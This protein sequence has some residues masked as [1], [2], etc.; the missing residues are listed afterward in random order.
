MKRALTLM[1][2]LFMTLTVLGQ[3]A[4]VEKSSF[5]YPKTAAGG[6]AKAFIVANNVG[7]EA[8]F[9]AFNEKRSQRSREQVPFDELLPQLLALR[10]QLGELV[11]HSVVEDTPEHVALLVHY[12]GGGAWGKLEIRCEKQRPHRI[13]SFTIVP[14]AP[15]EVFNKS[16]DMAMGLQSL[17][18]KA[19]SDGE[20]PAIAV[21][22]ANKESIV[23]AA[24]TGMRTAGGK[25][26]VK[27]TDR[28]HIGSI[29]KAM[30][31]TVAARLVEAG[32][33]SWK[34]SIADHFPELG[35][36]NPYST[37]ELRQVLRHS[38][39]IPPHTNFDMAGMKAMHG[40][41]GSPSQKREAW[42]RGVLQ[43]APVA[44]V[45]ASANYSNA[46]YSLV[47]VM[48]E[49]AS[50]KAFEGLMKAT[51]F[52]PLQLTSA[53][54]GWPREE[55]ESAPNGHYGRIVHRDTREYFLGPCLAPAGDVHLSVGDL[56]QFGRMHLRGLLGEDGLLQAKTI[57]ELHRPSVKDGHA[58]G[59]M[60]K[61]DA[62]KRPV[63]WHNG[64]AGT[65]YALLVIYPQQE[66][67]VAVAM[68]TAN[69]LSETIAW[70]IVAAIQGH[71]DE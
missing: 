48:A 25:E 9:R 29:S 10:A 1:L 64:T 49:R 35:E 16:Y 15:P 65:F 63:H 24:A 61:T 71:K 36:K 37:A 22:I 4:E 18:D 56:A 33:L 3:E 54:F 27:V 44:K 38:A 66:L 67:V 34:T 40:L 68:N 17:L 41:P 20:F 14:A 69:Q 55:H 46:G 47:A 21:A 30:T 45:G 13:E 52:E 26:R 70:K 57:K 42:I 19:C 12:G 28:F 58:C 31:A 2:V 32:E 39:G 5:E 51:L 8:A 11:P 23:Q 43:E 7:D 59:W 50:K 62:E 6:G 60:I 53:G